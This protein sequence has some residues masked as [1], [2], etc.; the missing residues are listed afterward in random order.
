MVGQF[1]KQILPRTRVIS[2]HESIYN[3]RRATTLRSQRFRPI[4][5][6]PSPEVLPIDQSVVIRPRLLST[7]Y[8]G[9]HPSSP[10]G[11]VALVIRRLRHHLAAARARIGTPLSIPP[12]IRTSVDRRATSTRART[13]PSTPA[14]ARRP[15]RRVRTRRRAR[16]RGFASRRLEECRACVHP[17]RV[18]A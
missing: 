11:A 2:I 16:W 4:L 3:L 7:Q 1:V 9:R 17:R 12:P 18:D 14:S 10:L 5:F 15:P 6:Q 8:T 13:P